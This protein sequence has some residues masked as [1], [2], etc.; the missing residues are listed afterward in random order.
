MKTAI[1][2]KP[3]T[4]LRPRNCY[5]PKTVKLRAQLRRGKDGLS[6]STAQF[7]AQENPV[8]R[9]PEFGDQSTDTVQSL[10]IQE[11]STAGKGEVGS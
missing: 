2:V 4:S 5:R 1:S 9:R 8:K 11:N 6:F 7:G 3:V 10:V